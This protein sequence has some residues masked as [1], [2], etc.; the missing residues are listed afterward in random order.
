M[1][2]FS[3]PAPFLIGG[4]MCVLKDAIHAYTTNANN[5]IL[6]VY[7]DYFRMYVSWKKN[8]STSVFVDFQFEYKKNVDRLFATVLYQLQD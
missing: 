7:F 2:N 3:V 4:K 8:F 6:I 5:F 1:E